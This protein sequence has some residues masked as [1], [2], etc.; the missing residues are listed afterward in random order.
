MRLDL[1]VAS[2]M[3]PNAELRERLRRGGVS[4]AELRVERD[5]GTRLGLLERNASL[6]LYLHVFGD[7][8]SVED[9]RCFYGLHLWPE[10]RFEVAVSDGLL[11][12][13]GF[14]LRG[15]PLCRLLTV[16]SA[17]EVR[18]QFRIGYHTS[19]EVQ[20]SLGAPSRVTGWERMED[21]SYRLGSSGEITFAFDFELLGAI[22]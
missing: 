22:S 4:D 12:L 18:R 10:H 21:W 2:L 7:P 15:S 1:F 20:T 5:R 17:D 14:S 3:R 9:G 11:S 19:A 13:G 8:E 16:G 6:D